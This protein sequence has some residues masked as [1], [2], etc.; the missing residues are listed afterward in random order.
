MDTYA[1]WSLA[2]LAGLA[3]PA[4]A[5]DCRLALVLA[6]DVSSS[7]DEDEYHLQKEGLA[8]ALMAPEVVRGFLAGDP[9]ALFVFDWSGPSTQ[10]PLPP[11]WQVIHSAQDLAQV[12]A[13]LTTQPRQGLD[14]PDRSTG[15]G[16]ALSFAAHALQ[17]GPQC[18]ARTVD[19]SGDGTSNDGLS[20]GFVYRHY[21][22]DGVTV[23]AL[24]VGTAWDNGA[25]PGAEAELVTWFQM[26]VMHG[27]GAF[28]VLADGYEDYERAMTVK[29]LRELQMPLVSGV[30][31]TGAGGA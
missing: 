16:T 12:A 31:V 30:P 15:L 22:F 20:P 10:V 25:P 7:V 4:L 13:A 14:D 1:A 5:G 24:V 2:A 26:E 21:P 28:L 18:R 29:L 11:G 3:S 9:V 27:P 6:L 23:N 17:D 19:V 8:R